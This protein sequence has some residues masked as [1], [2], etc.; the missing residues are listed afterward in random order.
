M[1]P[2]PEKLYIVLLIYIF[3]GNLENDKIEERIY[4]LN[5]FFKELIQRPIL[6]YSEEFQF[7]LRK[8]IPPEDK[9]S[10]SEKYLL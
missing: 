6:W 10:I 7:F 3:K 1:P 8:E 2:L 9:K 5:Y 4:F